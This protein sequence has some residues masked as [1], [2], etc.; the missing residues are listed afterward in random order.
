MQKIDPTD[1]ITAITH[2]RVFD[3]ERVI[4][5]QTVT[6]HGAHIHSVGGLISAGATVIDAHG[7]TLLPGLI[8][9]HTHTDLNGLH[10]A[11]L[12]GVTTELEMNGHWTARQRQAVAARSD[13]ADLRS[14][15][16]GVTPK[17]G[18]P[19]Q[20][21]RSSSNL[22]IRFLFRYPSVSTPAEAAKFVARQVAGGADYVKIFIEDGECIGYPGLPLLDNATLLAAVQAAHSF[23][24][25]AIAHV[26]TLAGTQQALSAGVDG[27]AHL[28]FDRRPSPAFVAAMAASGAFVIPT[29]VTISSALGQNAA[30][31]AA[32]P[33][34]RS[35]LD[36]KWLAS[37]SRSANVYPQGKL[38]DAFASVMALHQAG[39]DLLAGSDVSEPLPM[40]GGLAHG[41]S[42]HQ[43]L[44]LLVAAGLTPIQALRAATSTPARC[45]GL[46]DRGRIA[47]GMRADLL[48]VD[49]DPTTTISDTLS[50]RAVWRSGVQLL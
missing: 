48:L 28:F 3:G 4:D 25:L 46:T 11:L 20:Y 49:G 8:D 29:L 19:T 37:L 40:L 34:V 33:Q 39:V 21:M 44:Q 31:L 26:T 43:E 6:I 45:F 9:S 7:A 30:A 2:A 50:I 24:K 10:D 35:R 38:E 17:G 15:G 32:N 1:R 36:A 41:A 18:H 22:I 16:M 23:K 12:F 47:P 5:D 13:I 14:S 42:L 27:M